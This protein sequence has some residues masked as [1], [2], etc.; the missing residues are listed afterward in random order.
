MQITVSRLTNDLETKANLE[1]IPMKK[2]P[3]ASGKLT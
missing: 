1:R 3:L 2:Y